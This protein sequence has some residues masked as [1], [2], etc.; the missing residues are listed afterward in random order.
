M[1]E[2]S[3]VL[4]YDLRSKNASSGLFRKDPDES[5]FRFHQDRFPVI[6][7]RVIG[8]DKIDTPVSE[9]HFGETYAGDL[10]IG[11]NHVEHVIVV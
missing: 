5:V 11:E 10:G 8:D 6:V 3:G 1:N 2:L 9:N 7:E 4:G